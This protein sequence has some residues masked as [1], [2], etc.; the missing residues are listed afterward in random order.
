VQLCRAFCAYANGGRLVKPTLIR[1]MLDADGNVVSRNKPAQSDMLPQV[2]NRYT[3][4]QMRQTLCDVVVRGTASKAR[5]DTWNVF[6]KTG[7]AHVSEGRA[8][9][10]DSRYTSSFLCGAPAERPRLVA[11]FI[12]HEPDKQW[13]Q[14]QNLSHYGGAVAAPGATRM[15]ER[16]LAY[17]QVPPSPPLPLPPEN[18]QKVLYQ[19]SKKAY[20]QKQPP[21]TAA[22][23]D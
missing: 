16:C 21:Q 9:Y 17:L 22:A 19:F 2:L 11:A 23:R 20:E 8:G 1:G 6:G 14:S 4:L 13:A 12:V 15:L 3:A 7:T 5:S 10:S 18:V